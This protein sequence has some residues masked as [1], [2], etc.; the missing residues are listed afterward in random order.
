MG[1]VVGNVEDC[2]EMFEGSAAQTRITPF[3]STNQI[4]NPVAYKL[5]RVCLHI[6]L[7]SLDVTCIVD[8]LV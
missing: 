5:V 8:P 6:V 4:K 3:S 2:R 7:S 1:T